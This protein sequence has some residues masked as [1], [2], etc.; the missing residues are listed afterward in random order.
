MYWVTLAKTQ[1]QAAA[2]SGAAA[3]ST[4]GTEAAA[5]V[6]SNVCETI[7]GIFSRIDTLAHPDRLVPYVQ[8]LSVVWAV[9]FLIAGM[10]CLLNGYRIY[11]PVIILSGLTLGILAGYWLGE[12]INAAQIVAGCL[13]LLL[14]V[15]FFPLMKY[16]VAGLGALAGAFI[17]A[18]AWTSITAAAVPPEAA[19][20]AAQNYWIGALIGLLVFGMLAFI[21]F[22]LSIIVFTTVSGSTLVVLG[23]MALLLQIPAWR[24]AITRSISAHAA[25]L[26]LLVFVPAVIGL[27]L[28][29][30][31]RDRSPAKASD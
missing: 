5:P 30:S 3:G 10:I 15:A 24:G 14:A 4:A 29:E 22:K 31:Q 11:R 25:V 21:V 12:K 2:D 16:A 7:N 20:N 1:G 23:A 19:A 26:P 27:I 28:Q 17:G 6:A 13:G 9:V 18:N 8:S